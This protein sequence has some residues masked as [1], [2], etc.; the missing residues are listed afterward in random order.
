MMMTEKKGYILLTDTGTVFTN[1]IKLFTNKPYNHAS[2]A[3]DSDLSEVYSFGRKS[4]RNP[5]I[6][7]F[8]EEDMKSRLF[9]QADCEIY[10]FEITEVQMQKMKHYILEIEAEKNQ[11]RYNFLGLFGFILNRPIERK[12]SFFCSQF[13]ASVLEEGNV[14]DFKKPLSLIAPNDFQKLTNLQLMYQGKLTDYTNKKIG[15]KARFPFQLYLSRFS[16]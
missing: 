8:V 11:Y 1:L 4:I 14:I 15:E 10:S 6:G 9:N 2:I 13:V 3:F 7:G 16:A 12:K 5:F